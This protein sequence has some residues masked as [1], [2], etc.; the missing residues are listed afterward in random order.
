[1]RPNLFIIGSMKSGTTYL[2]GLLAE[3]PAVFV[4]SPKEPCYFVDQKTLRRVWPDRKLYL[5][6]ANDYLSLFA[7]AGDAA[8]IAEAST[9]YSQLPVFPGVAERILAF[10]PK[11]RFIYI[12][13]DPVER[14]ISHYW[15]RVRWWGER[16][17][18]RAA[19]RLDP[20]YREVSH[21]ARQL[22]AYLRHVE[23][24]RIYVLTY[25][26]L[27]S[28]PFEQLQHIYAWLGVAGDFR[29]AKLGIPNNV[30]PD[31]IEQVRGFGLL[32]RLRHSATYHK[33]GRYIP[34]PVRS[35]AAGLAVRPLRPADL[36]TSEV[37]SLLR[38]QQQ[39][40]TEELG[41]LLKRSI[42]EWTTLYAGETPH[43]TVAARYSVGS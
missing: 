27:V 17:S 26:A 29:P 40:E 12:M 31:V 37:R 5:Q 22:N 4:S 6:R 10:S 8:V 36:D 28:R 1:M 16:R 13:R 23:R 11:A 24:D 7:A 2:S 38:P 42:P 32:D 18:L 35:F 15:H 9:V 25:E 21:Y 33:V 3:H 41:R 19:L 39:L 43:L 14:T 30:L 34:R 20:H